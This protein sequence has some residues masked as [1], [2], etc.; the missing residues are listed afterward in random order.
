[1]RSVDRCQMMFLILSVGISY[2]GFYA[3]DFKGLHTLWKGCTFLFCVPMIYMFWCFRLFEHTTR[4]R[5]PS[6]YIEET[7]DAVLCLRSYCFVNYIAHRHIDMILLLLFLSSQQYLAPTHVLLH[8]CLLNKYDQSAL[9]CC[10]TTMLNFHFFV[11]V[12][13]NFRKNCRNLR[14]IS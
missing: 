7:H 12:Y 1:M 2:R 11:L 9:I 13:G 5:F 6:L 10:L 14:G 4:I 3:T 8:G